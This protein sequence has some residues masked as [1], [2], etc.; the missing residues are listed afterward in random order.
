VG[1]LLTIS[2]VSAGCTREE[3]T[4]Y[5]KARSLAQKKLSAKDRGKLFETE[6]VRS[7]DPSIRAI[8]FL[9]QS[10]DARGNPAPVTGVALRPVG[11]PPPGGFPLIAYAHPTAGQADACAPSKRV[12][13]MWEMR[14][15]VDAGYAVVITDY[16]G[17]GT[18]GAHAYLHGPSEARSVLDSI[19]AA[20]AM[21]GLDASPDKTV[22]WGFSQ[23]G[24]AALWASQDA[25]AL[26]EHGVAGV[27][28]LA[29]L[30]TPRV[31]VDG[32]KKPASPSFLFTLATLG[33]WSK[34]FSQPLDGVL[35]PAVIAQVDGF[36]D[37]S[38]DTCPEVGN[39][40]AATEK[41]PRV[42]SDP[43][44]NP[45]WGPIIKDAMELPE[46]AN[47]VPVLIIVGNQ[48]EIV[49][50]SESAHA[51]EVLCSQGGVVSYNIIKGGHAEASNP[52]APL[53]WVAERLAGNPAPSNC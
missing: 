53:A 29:G 48:D 7:P 35:T 50:A 33:S 15:L 16:P 18:P 5:T 12:S 24:Q 26:K 34:A 14:P 4:V 47:A 32:I 43:Q 45:T 52:A 6:E 20:R 2:V 40:L 46:L 49:P 23:G 27:V 11:N 31:L 36:T 28:A 3:P 8:R 17:L 37:D 13:G 51:R 22:V 38:A 25:A 10:S 9:Y 1:L 21:K 41:D 30:S 44:Q 42:L 19:S 39:G